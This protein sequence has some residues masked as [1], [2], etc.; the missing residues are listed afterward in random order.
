MRFHRTLWPAAVLALS[1]ALLAPAAPAAAA[2]PPILG[3][4]TVAIKDAPYTAFIRLNG[5][6]WKRCGGTIVA[7]RKVVTAAHCVRAADNGAASLEVITGRT[8]PVK[9]TGG[10]LAKVTRAWIHPDY[11]KLPNP[12]N[13]DIAV[14]TLDSDASGTALALPKQG[15]TAFT[16]AGTV[17]TLYGWGM[18]SDGDPLTV[19]ESLRTLNETILPAADCTKAEK[20][21]DAKTMLCASYTAN[22]TGFC[23][24]DSGGPLVIG[25]KLAGVISFNSAMGCSAPDRADFYMRASAYT[26]L[27]KKQIDTP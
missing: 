12:Q 18:T 24:G 7:P 27:I 2:P 20:I 6:D 4:K 16:A 21:H 1:A 22:S 8:K 9:D 14:L 23:S 26:D 3:G 19:S 10:K 17:G 11:G 5:L 13:N 25:G 15:E